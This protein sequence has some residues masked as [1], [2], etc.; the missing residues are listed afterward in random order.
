[1][2]KVYKIQD[3]D[4]ILLEGT[5]GKVI[6]LSNIFYLNSSWNKEVFDL[7]DENIITIDVSKYNH[8]RAYKYYGSLIISEKIKYGRND[9][10]YFMIN[11]NGDITKL[12]KIGGESLCESGDI[13]EIDKITIRWE[14]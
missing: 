1:M 10:T 11:P 14:R 3:S 8:I 12:D 13:T 9:S 2:I 6:G 7:F 4:T 5:N